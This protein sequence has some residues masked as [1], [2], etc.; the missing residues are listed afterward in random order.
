MA[1]GHTTRR[2]AGTLIVV[3]EGG[4]VERDTQSCVHCGRHW[5]VQ[6]GSGKRRGWCPWHK[7]P[8]CGSEDCMYCQRKEPGM[9]FESRASS[10]KYQARELGHDLVAS[11]AM[12]KEA[13][14][15]L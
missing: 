9:Q 10:E 4:S 2:P 3:A 7:A 14:L 13:G 8:H 12:H 1:D 11:A 5:I 6:P 15:V